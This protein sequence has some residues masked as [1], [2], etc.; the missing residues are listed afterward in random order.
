M[1][2]PYGMV[3]VVRGVAVGW[4]TVRLAVLGGNLRAGVEPL[5][6]SGRYPSAILA[7]ESRSDT[8]R[9]KTGGSGVA[10]GSAKR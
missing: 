2:C 3:A 4:D 1:P 8:V 9:F 5:P 7:Q 6:R 10:S